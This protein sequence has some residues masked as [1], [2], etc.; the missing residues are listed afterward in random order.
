MSQLHIWRAHVSHLWTVMQETKRDCVS[1]CGFA[2]E[3]FG[4]R[5]CLEALVLH[6][7][8]AV[9]LHSF[10][11]GRSKRPPS[12]VIY[13]GEGEEKFQN[14]DFAVFRVITIPELRHQ[15]QLLCNVIR[16]LG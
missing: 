10:V 6:R 11:N 1:L 4:L 5:K 15:R 12:E 2:L 13:L 3:D 16:S 8:C 7:K 14:S 9:N